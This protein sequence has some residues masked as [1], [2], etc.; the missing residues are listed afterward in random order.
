[1]QVVDQK[2]TSSKSEE[3]SRGEQRPARDNVLITRQSPILDV[4]TT[5]PRRIT[6]GKASTFVVAITNSGPVA[7]DQTVV[8]IDL[9]E[10]SEVVGTEST[11]GTAGW[12]KPGGADR[13]FQWTVGRLEAKGHE[14]LTL[15]IM[16]LK[17]QPFDLAVKWDYR[18]VASQAVIEVEEP[19]VEL[20]LDGPDEILYGASRSTVS[21]CSIPATATPRTWRSPSRRSGRAT[22]CRP[23]TR[24]ASCAGTKK[25]MEV[26]L[27]ARQSGELS[28]EVGAHADGGVEAKLLKKIVVVRP[29]L[30]VQIESPQM[31]YAGA[32]AAY[33]I[34]V[35]NSG[36][37]AARNVI[38]SAAIPAGTRKTSSE[39]AGQ[40]AADGKE[41]SW[42]LENL[43]RARRRA[44]RSFAHW[45]R[46]ASGI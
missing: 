20:K 17:S 3:S 24:W 18:P 46:P 37:A 11:A 32:E 25:S 21:S 36:T 12:A 42:T 6:V 44:S 14:E 8:T 15:K 30:N 28:V 23:R 39:P 16:P 9:P 33:Q 40:L 35:T 22:T 5:G 19:K 13:Q 27:T 29:A 26:E 43:G 38:V 7:A 31:R 1:M 34:L 2:P 45:S 4:R 41:L 10:W